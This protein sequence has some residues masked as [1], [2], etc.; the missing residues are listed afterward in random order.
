MTTDDIFLRRA[1]LIDHVKA[2]PGIK[3]NQILYDWQKSSVSDFGELE[4]GR[5]T[6]FNELDKIDRMFG[7]H[8][9]TKPGKRYGG[10]F[11]TNSNGVF[12]YKIHRWLLSIIDTGFKVNR[13]THLYDRFLTDEFPSENG[14]LKPII[15]AME[16]DKKIN[17]IYK[18]YNKETST[19]KISPYCI[20]T[21]KHRF[22]VL[23]RLD[24]GHFRI[25]SFDRMKDVGIT[26]EGFTVSKD[27]DAEAFFYNFYGVFI[28]T[29]DE[30]PSDIIVRAYEDEWNYLMDVP[31]HHSQHLVCRSE[32]YA[33][34]CITIFPTNDFIGDILQQAGRLEIISPVSVRLK[35]AS[36]TDRLHRQYT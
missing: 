1:W 24:S 17:I 34:F 28:N 4:M 21:Y 5:S 15:E 16:T 26:E 9:S 3:L 2:H 29:E 35:I 22:Y 25:Y 33:D 23:G 6:F 10:Y 30:E 27:F 14:R 32:N 18:P 12:D 11:V 19:T 7:I 31:L 20:K 13:C 8:I 36:I